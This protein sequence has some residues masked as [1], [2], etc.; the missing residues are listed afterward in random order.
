MPSVGR[1][2]PKDAYDICY[3]L[4]YFPEGIEHLAVSWRER[5]EDW[6]VVRSIEILREKFATVD[7]FGPLQVV[8]FLDVIDADEKQ[9]QARRAFELVQKFVGML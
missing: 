6:E 5:R 9:I 8:E 1:D 2:K 3:C 4:G 7:S